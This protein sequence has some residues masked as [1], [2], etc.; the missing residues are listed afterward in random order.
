[1]LGQIWIQCC[2]AFHT[3]AVVL[4]YLFQRSESA[5]VHVRTSHFHMPKRWHRELTFVAIF[6]ADFITSGILEMRIQAII[7]KSLAL[8]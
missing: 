7:R 5:V 2:G 4:D 1:M 3:R 8:K 6:A